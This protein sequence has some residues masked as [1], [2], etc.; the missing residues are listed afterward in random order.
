MRI[1][2]ILAKLGLLAALSLSLPA[3]GP[4]PDLLVSTDWLATRLDDPKL[5]LLHV[6]GEQKSYQAGHIPG[7]RFLPWSE[8]VTTREGIWTE[9]PPVADLQRLF[10][11]LGVSD[12][13]RVILYGDN[14]VLAAAR[15]YFT[16]DYLGHG[17]HA[18]LL[19][20]GLEKWRA[21]GRAV[22]AQTPEWKPGRLTP[23]PRPEVVPDLEAVRNRAPGRILLD[24]RPAAEYAAGHIGGAIN[25]FWMDGLLSKDNPV[26]R[27]IPELRR[28][29]ETAGMPPGSRV[30]T[31]CWVGLQ[32]SES[33]FI[34]KYLGYDP[35]LYDGSFT[36]WSSKGAPVV[37]GA[38]PDPGPQNRNPG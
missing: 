24:A 26:L 1:A 30:V 22:S 2:T 29:Y 7:A 27:P 14:L 5:V 33:Y 11:R 21:E 20:G 35:A 25:L 6:T 13:T 36:D 32:A 23:H 10:E 4:R 8:L 37:A 12:D 31:Y 15:A 18:A 19:D 34:L 16:L 9:L 38:S 3:A 17:E 28:L